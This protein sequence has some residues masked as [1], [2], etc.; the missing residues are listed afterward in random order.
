MSP[1]FE[2][3]ISRCLTLASACKEKIAEIVPSRLHQEA[4]CVNETE[5][6]Y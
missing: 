5:G 1:G 4:K 6:L 2:K 3:N